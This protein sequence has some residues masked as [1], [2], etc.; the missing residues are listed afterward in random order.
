VPGDYPDLGGGGECPVPGDDEGVGY[1]T[2]GRQRVPT[3]W[4]LLN[5]HW[6]C[7]LVPC[8]QRAL[9]TI[10]STPPPLPEF[11]QEDIVYPDLYDVDAEEIGRISPH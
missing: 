3:E 2:V 7:Q 8:T 10:L 1:W 11:L 9:P 5:Q 4:T 6:T